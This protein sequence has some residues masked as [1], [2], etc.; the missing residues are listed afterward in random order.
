MG[1]NHDPPLRLSCLRG[2]GGSGSSPTSSPWRLFQLDSAR[3]NRR[4]HRVIPQR[5]TTPCRLLASPAR[6]SPASATEQKQHQDNMSIWFPRLTCA[7]RDTGGLVQ[8]AA[9]LLPHKQQHHHG[10]HEGGRL[11]DCD[12]VSEPLCT[13][14]YG[15]RPRKDHRGHR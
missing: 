13:P 6:I 10:R 5:G 15:L 2:Y 4:S 7:V 8:P 9:R 3:Q 11:S 1:N 12:Q 14:P